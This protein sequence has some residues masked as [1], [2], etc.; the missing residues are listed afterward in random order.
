MQGTTETSTPMSR[1]AIMARVRSKDTRPELTIRRGLHALGYRFR[2]HRS[3]LPGRP[4]LT[5]SRYRAVIEVRGCFWHGHEGCG[6]RPNSRREFWDAKID[7]N[8]ARDE[9]NLAALR[10]Q[11]WRVLVVWECAMVG[12]GRWEADALIDAVSDWLR[13][14]EVVGQIAGRGVA[15]GF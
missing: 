3:D 10:E 1:S 12:P 8:R 7:G 5:L 9:R 4:D 15:R 11:G 14:S 13:E 6:R 2:L